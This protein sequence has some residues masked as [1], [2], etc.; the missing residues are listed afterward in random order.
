MVV[1]TEHISLPRVS[2]EICQLFIGSVVLGER[3]LQPTPK[4]ARKFHIVNRNQM[5]KECLNG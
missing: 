1:W 5:S 4:V 2:V 3:K